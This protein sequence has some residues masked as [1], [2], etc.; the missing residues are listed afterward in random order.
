MEQ[1][2]KLWELDKIPAVLENKKRI[3]KLY[4]IKNRK[5]KE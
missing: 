2:L 1:F 3:Q 4:T 5:E